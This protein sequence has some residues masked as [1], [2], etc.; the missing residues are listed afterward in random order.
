MF[1]FAL[2]KSIT[3]LQVYLKILGLI[4]DQH[5]FYGICKYSGDQNTETSGISMVKICLVADVGYSWKP[6]Y[7]NLKRLHGAPMYCDSISTWQ[8][9][10]LVGIR[11]FYLRKDE[12]TVN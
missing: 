8:I 2:I 4:F 1:T 10:I 11:A 9:N 5:N 6:D 12:N 7:W 3:E